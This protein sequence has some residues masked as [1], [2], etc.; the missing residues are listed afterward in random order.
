MKKVGVKISA[1]IVAVIV[2]FFSLVYPTARV[3]AVKNT[4]VEYNIYNGNGDYQSSY[5]LPKVAMLSESMQ[6]GSIG[7]D[8]REVDFSKNGVCKLVTK[9]G[10]ESFCSTGFVI[11]SHTIATAA[12]CVYDVEEADSTKVSPNTEIEHI[13]FF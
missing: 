9:Q 6:R 4:N 12:H 13:L 7:I 2:A 10:G 3:G 8:N 1:A 5:T 11:D